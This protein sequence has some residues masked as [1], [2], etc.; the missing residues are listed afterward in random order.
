MEVDSHSDQIPQLP[1]SGKG[2]GCAAC[3]DLF[4]GGAKG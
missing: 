2:H 4:F 3:K 1:T